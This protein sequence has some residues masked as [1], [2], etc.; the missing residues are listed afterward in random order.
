MTA[1]GHSSPYRRYGLFAAAGTMAVLAMSIGLLGPDYWYVAWLLALSAVT[2][3]Y[4][5]FDKRR[6][7]NGGDRVPELVL[8]LLALAGGFPGGWLGRAAFR[9]KT[10]HPS[11]TI[12]LALATLL[13]AVFVVWWFLVR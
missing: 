11:F 4:Y 13:H 5:W 2:C 8:H 12:V 7:R 6:A 9:H 3:A 10:Q 1:R